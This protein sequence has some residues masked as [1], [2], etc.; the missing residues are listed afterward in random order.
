M[1]VTVAAFGDGVDALRAHPRLLVG[2]LLVGVARHPRFV[3]R[4]IDAPGPSAGVGLACLLALPFVAGGFVGLARAALAG[5][6]VSAGAFLASA[7]THYLRLGAGICLFVVLVVGVAI[8]LGLVSLAVGVGGLLLARV[9]EAASVA[10]SVGAVAVWAAALFG[11]V[12]SVQ[13]FTAA[14]VIEGRGVVASFRRSVS[15]VRSHPASV[16]GFSILWSGASHL[17][18]VPGY[19]VGT[20]ATDGAGAGAVT[21]PLVELAVPSAVA[22]PVAIGVST[23]A[24]AYLYT[25]YVAYYVRLTGDESASDADADSDSGSDPGSGFDADADSGAGPESG[26]GSGPESGSGSTPGSDTT[27]DSGPGPGSGPATAAGRVAVTATVA[28]D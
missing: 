7:R 14:I 9:S 20:P 11:V 12:L 28:G 6:E 27:S 18:V 26:S 23:V 1:T 5:E 22:A 25:V 4:V 13:F 17:V 10:A 21:T 16:L 19:A 8:G 15:L 2:G 24:S 3:D